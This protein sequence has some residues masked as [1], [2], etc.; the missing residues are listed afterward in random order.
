VQDLNAN[1]MSLWRGDL[2]LFD[3][4]VFAG[5]P[6]NGG[7]AMDGFSCCLMHWGWQVS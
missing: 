4:E 2:D 5:S 6:A 3:L 1:F 7:F